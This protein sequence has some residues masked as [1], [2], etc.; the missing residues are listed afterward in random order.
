MTTEE[1]PQGQVPVVVIKKNADGDASAGLNKQQPVIIYL[2]ATGAS[3]NEMLGYMETAASKGYIAVAIDCRYHGG[4][5][6]SKDEYKKALIKAWVDDHDGSN[7]QARPFLLDTVWDLIRLLD[8]LGTRGDVDQ[9]R[10]GM[11]GI[12]LGGMHTWLTAAVDTRVAVAVP[13]IGVQNFRWAVEQNRWQA[14]VASIPWVFDKARMD[15]AKTQVDS[16]V[17]SAV[18]SR[19]APGL[20]DKLDSSLTLPMIAP[21]PLLV[22]NGEEDP[23]CPVEGLEE[24]LQFTQEA[25]EALSAIQDFQFRAEKGVGHAMTPNMAEAAEMWFDKYLH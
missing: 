23:R 22:L 4:R 19:I 8:Y 16:E 12:S 15:L 14:R 13:M 25:Y 2:H 20:L 11:T 9:S 3:I 24:P 17:V 18:W 5:A 6:Y 1:G 7:G 10:I 21:R